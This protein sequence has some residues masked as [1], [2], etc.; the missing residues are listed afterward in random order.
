MDLETFL[1]VRLPQ[2]PEMCPTALFLTFFSSFFLFN[3][4]N[5][6]GWLNYG[7]HNQFENNVPLDELAMP[8]EIVEAQEIRLFLVDVEEGLGAGC[9]GVVAPL[10][11]PSLPYHLLLKHHA[12]LVIILHLLFEGFVE[13]LLLGWRSGEGYVGGDG[14]NPLQQSF[15][16]RVFSILF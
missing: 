8:L 2:L 9:A 10:L 1:A 6:L 15:L 4:L 16:C 11:T 5:A 14:E 12:I 7:S 13:G 3:F